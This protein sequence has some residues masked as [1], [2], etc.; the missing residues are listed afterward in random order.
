LADDVVAV[1]HLLDAGADV[2]AL[3]SS[4]ETVLHRCSD[5]KILRLIA[6]RADINVRT[7]NGR[8]AL[9]KLLAIGDS[10]ES[11]LERTLLLVRAGIDVTLTDDEGNS[12]LHYAVRIINTHQHTHCLTPLVAAMIAKGANVNLAN[13]AGETPMHLFRWME[14]CSLD[15]L[16][17]LVKAGANLEAKDID[18]RTPLMAWAGRRHSPQC[19]DIARIYDKMAEYGASFTT[20]DNLGRTLL[21][22][23]VPQGEDISEFIDY[24]NDHGVDPKQ[25]DNAGNTLWHAA[26]PSFCAWFHAQG[27]YAQITQL[28]VDPWAP[29]A[30]GH[31]PLHSVCMYRQD[32]MDV[33]DWDHN[34]VLNKAYPPVLDYMMSVYKDVD[35]G[36]NQ[37]ITPLHYTSTFSEMLT[38]FLLQNGADAF[39]ATHEGLTTLHLA[40]RSRQ[41]NIV[42]LLLENLRSTE[43]DK[44]CAAAVNAKDS[45]G[46][47][48]LYYACRSGRVESVR[49]LLNAGATVRIGPFK[50][51]AWH[52]CA[53]FESELDDRLWSRRITEAASCYPRYWLVSSTG[54]DKTQSWGYFE[55]FAGSCLMTT[56]ERPVHVIHRDTVFQSS[57][58]FPMERLQDIVSLLAAHDLITTRNSIGEAIKLAV[59]RSF[60]YTVEV[61]SKLQQS[62]GLRQSIE[63]E[64]ALT[65]CIK[66]RQAFLDNS[67][68]EASSFQHQMELRD[69][70]AA[71]N[72]IETFE[73]LLLHDPQNALHVMSHLIEGGYAWLIDQLTTP[74]MV[75]DPETRIE[76]EASQDSPNILKPL[77]VAACQRKD[78]NIE[79]L[80]VLVQKGA[81]LNAQMQSTDETVSGRSALHFLATSNNWWQSRLAIPFLV[82]HGADMELKDSHGRTPLRLALNNAGAPWFNFEAVKML[83]EL[84]AN[85]NA[86]DTEE[87]SCLQKACQCEKTFKLLLHHGAVVSYGDILNPI[88]QKDL[89]TLELILRSGADPNIRDPEEEVPESE[90]TNSEID[91]AQFSDPTEDECDYPLDFVIYNSVRYKRDL[92]ASIRICKLLLKFGAD[93]AA[94]YSHTTVMHR[95]LQVRTRVYSD[96]HKKPIPLLPFFKLFVDHPGFD[97]E[98]RDARGYTMLHYACQNRHELVQLLIKHMADVRARDPD[99]QLPIHIYL[100]SPS[101]RIDGVNVLASLLQRYQAPELLNERDNHDMSLLHLALQDGAG[102]KKAEL[103][104]D[105]SIEVCL[106]PTSAGDTLLHFLLKNTWLI[107]EHGVICGRLRKQFEQF[108]ASGASIN[109]RNN[110]GETPIFN[111]FRMGRIISQEQIELQKEHPRYMEVQALSGKA[112]RIALRGIAAVEAEPLIWAFLDEAHV[113]W[114]MKNKKGQSLLHIVAADQT[115]EQSKDNNCQGR[116]VARFRFLLSKGL[117]AMAEDEE[118]HTALDTAAAQDNQDILGLFSSSSA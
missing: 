30:V 16:A 29:N 107:D 57:G 102:L 90:V 53:D 115:Q 2:H 39:R 113:D 60:D 38:A 78:P 34:Y 63:F 14:C 73:N 87:V 77:I 20:T 117:D 88:Y 7:P 4:G 51:S 18:G 114:A 106:A 37:G 75:S 95:V 89:H 69:F 103:L 81:N 22:A 94:N 15:I 47:T 33:D 36:D 97:I 79:V 61:L 52:G 28:G 31:T 84:G 3:T 49:L 58:Q 82:K 1:E 108:L 44:A 96:E 41:A 9:T 100:Q 40:A 8:T 83:L 55:A 12:A 62:L 91:E 76:I 99:G 68:Q 10:S 5:D 17:A 19:P 23:A 46:R 66:N 86:V 43:S 59:E 70:D 26:I 27:I 109:M 112:K 45:L 24:L 71:V 56:L 13:N 116:R 110:D 25:T 80:R 32:F 92:E 118:H 67:L 111:F 105:A 11:L 50:G 93:P 35:C 85:P 48:A 64:T 72:N 98:A 6:K 42:G 65:A 54:A 21:H 74:E 104:L 101:R